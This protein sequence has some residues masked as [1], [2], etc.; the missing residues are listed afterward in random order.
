MARATEPDFPRNPVNG[1]A[2][3]SKQQLAR[4]RHTPFQDVAVR[5]YAQALAK[6]ALEVAHANACKTGEFV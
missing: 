2:G 4:R 5:W 6:R 1:Q 3:L